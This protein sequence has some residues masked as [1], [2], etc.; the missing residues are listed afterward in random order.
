M[1]LEYQLEKKNRI[2]EQ[3]TEKQNI[4][5]GIPDKEITKK[6]DDA[7]K[8][9]EN[10][11]SQYNI[12]ISKSQYENNPI[13]LTN[14]YNSLAQICNDLTKNEEIIRQLN[15]ELDSKSK[16]NLSKLPAE[17]QLEIDKL[18]ND[19]S[20][21]DEQI[22]KE[23]EL[24]RQKQNTNKKYKGLEENINMNE[25]QRVVIDD[26]FGIYIDYPKNAVI[27][28]TIK[29]IFGAGLSTIPE[30]YSMSETEVIQS[31]SNIKMP[32][33]PTL[34]SVFIDTL[35]KTIGQG[36]VKQFFFFKNTID[37]IAGF[38]IGEV[39]GTMIPGL[40]NI[41]KDIKLLF[42]DPSQW[43][44][45][46][47]L[48]PIFDI[49]IPIPTFKF[50]LGALIPFL[51]F[52][53]RIPKIDPYNYFNKLTPFNINADPT[54][55]P[56]NWYEIM[57]NDIGK[58][59][60]ELEIN[61]KNI[62]LEKIKVLQGKIQKI[63]DDLNGV[64]KYESFIK[65]SERKIKILTLNNNKIKD[66]LNSNKFSQNYDYFIKKEKELKEN[67]ELINEENKKLSELRVS[68]DNEQK[69]LN[70]LNR[71]ELETQLS[72]YQNDLKELTDDE[73]PIITYK[74]FAKKALL[75]AYEQN[76]PQDTLVEKLSVLWDIG[77]NI[78]DNQVTE[79]LQKIGYDFTKN[80]YIYELKSLRDKF[81]LKFN[82]ATH[83]FKL[84]QLGFNLNDP[85]HLEKLKFL[86]R[87]NIDIKNADLMLIL[88]ELGMNL[89]NVLFYDIVNTLNNELSINISDLEILKKLNTIGFNFNNINTI[90]RLKILS[91][92]V[93][94]KTVAGYNN[95]I[96]KNVNLNNPYIETV[97]K[98]YFTLNLN[99]NS[100]DFLA[101]EAEILSTVTVQQIDRVKKILNFF[102]S[103]NTDLNL[104]FGKTTLSNNEFI[105]Y[106][107]SFDI[108]ET[109]SIMNAGDTAGLIIPN[110][111]EYK[112][113]II[114]SKTQWYEEIPV[115]KQIPGSYTTLINYGTYD[116]PIIEE[117]KP[118]KIKLYHDNG[119]V[120]K[121]TTNY[122][123]NVDESGV[124]NTSITY[125]Y[126]KLYCIPLSSR[127]ILD[128]VNR[129]SK[130]NIKLKAVPKNSLNVSN[131]STDISKPSLIQGDEY[132][133]VVLPFKGNEKFTGSNKNVENEILIKGVKEIYVMLDLLRNFVLNK[134]WVIDGVRIADN[135]SISVNDY[136]RMISTNPSLV[137]TTGAT[138]KINEITYDQL[139]GIYG[140]FDKLGLNIRDKEFDY[141]FQKMMDI[142]KI[143]IDEINILETKRKITLT[144]YDRNDSTGLYDIQK[145]ID[146]STTKPN[147][148]VFDDAR[149]NARIEIT[150]IVDTTKQ[151]QP[152]K[153]I[154]QFDSLNKMGFNFQNPTYDI[155]L[156]K[157]NG[158]L[159]NVS[160]FKTVDI[161]DALCALGWHYNSVESLNK[162]SGLAQLGFN[163]DIPSAAITDG[164]DM[165]DKLIALNNIG[166]NFN[167]PQWLNMINEL[168][169]I[170]LN[171]KDKDFEKAIEELISFGISFKDDDWNIKLQKL[172]DLGINFSTI[173]NVTN[174]YVQSGTKKWISQMS[175][176]ISLGI[177]F[178][179]DDWLIKY[180][181]A[182][183]LKKLGIDYLEIENRQKIAILN[184]LGVDFEQPEDDYM[185]KI[186]S[187]VQLKLISIPQNVVNTKIEYLKNREEKLTKILKRIEYLE[188]VLNGSIIIDIDNQ[189][190]KLKNLQSSY[191]I[192][193]KNLKS[194][195]ISNFNAIQINNLSKNLDEKC[196]LI[197]KLNDKIN[198][199]LDERKKT[200]TLNKI[201]IEAELF[202]LNDE[203]SKLDNKV[204][205]LNSDL[206]LVEL[207]KFEALEKIGVNFYDPNWMQ[208]ISMLLQYPFNFGMTDWKSLLPNVMYLIPRNPIL[209]WTKTIINT[210]T[211]V[212]T[213]PMK[214]IFELIK[215][216]IDLIGKVISIP[217]NP[218]KIPD[219]IIGNPSSTNENDWGIITRFRKLVELI[220]NLPTLDGM[221]DFLFTNPDG[222][223]LIDIFVKGFAEFMS[224]IKQ[225]TSN[226]SNQIKNL[227][228]ELGVLKQKLDTVTKDKNK[229]QNEL[230]S[231]LLLTDSIINGDFSDIEKL[232]IKLR[233]LQLV[234]TKN[235][236]V[237]E[238]SIRN[239]S[240]PDDILLILEKQLK[241]NCIIV[242]DL[243]KQIEENNK[244]LKELKNKPLSELQT[245]KIK[246]EN[247]LSN[248]DNV[249]NIGTI[250]SDI[251][252]KKLK[253]SEL[254][255]KVSV[256]GNFCNFKNNID[257]LIE[258][259]N[260]FLNNMNKTNPY[261]K[262]IAEKQKQ[263][264]KLKNKL[265]MLQ[266][267]INNNKNGQS[268]YNLI[269]N[270]NNQIQNNN[271]Q[272]NS[273]ESDLCKN[274][275]SM[276]DY[277][278]FNKM[279][280]IEELKR[281][282]ADIQNQIDNIKIN[283]GT[284]EQMLQTKL[285]IEAELEKLNKELKVLRN[286]QQEFNQ[287]NKDKESKFKNVITW[288]PTIINI[289]C[290]VP[291]FIVNICV[292]LFNAAGY[293]KNLPTLWEFSYVK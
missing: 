135:F 42:T 107:Y 128:I 103:P 87:L 58:D 204:Y 100:D 106:I 25:Y 274:K 44:F 201:D 277:E 133:P 73:K 250:Q 23:R 89:N 47:T 126:D 252:N 237:I 191:L 146:L 143:K 169:S 228:Q 269:N 285:E 82:N 210:I 271:L 3:I 34:L 164:V 241:E 79:F 157:L 96:K 275:N 105:K 208:N 84:Y 26:N 80:K 131:I 101:T 243:E 216:L 173:V 168:V 230:H 278:F 140:N 43:M 27:S 38:E 221:I 218:A 153:T 118:F 45:K 32:G 245:D 288:L 286:K 72:E 14:T 16:S 177:D 183:N 217:L 134:G 141:K 293:M 213:M 270:L 287:Q 142:L 33:L 110:N 248:I 284:N 193:I 190:K 255:E 6:I 223:M 54:K 247:Q 163:F 144:Y 93:D 200:I 60:E 283:S 1:S 199:L 48:G 224:L 154:I 114:E 264:N 85:N 170:G 95:A 86:S 71:L 91:K 9:R 92:Y 17:Y 119:Y 97:L 195:D 108:E 69:R 24:E 209:E 10:L 13:V 258:I 292:G 214:F 263:I 124:T 111:F 161:V 246:L 162:L 253:I 132:V 35:L 137:I 63:L 129:W 244:K 181:K 239:N 70:S 178:R 148:K 262:Q 165:D 231:Q 192:E 234:H 187:L 75:L 15:Q 176:L 261:D 37:L 123:Q 238:D 56:S 121:V 136:E 220:K 31:I 272:L 236:E 188:N 152:T 112:E 4:L 7:K 65:A 40:I 39:I 182:I 145:T 179:D 196:L 30:N 155:F 90:E 139:S 62:Q 77:V 186:E 22:A 53:I 290:C 227:N 28:E 158:L 254:S 76:I 267:N 19:L 159:F 74:Q 273:L 280:K 130:Y 55:I 67:C 291:K 115:K 36:F 194:I 78:F 160:A 49:N 171:M 265:N 122:S 225:L 276:S 281:N 172:K 64:N 215:K 212:I 149:Y 52:S 242:N 138:P 233:N 207:E 59:E 203:K 219:W 18:Y 21:I 257:K 156:N 117:G 279:S 259:M 174:S 235:I 206:I 211:T 50:D 198:K 94:I 197:T 147:P 5:A 185:Q 109:L 289:L 266:E 226:F 251:N 180:N 125:T 151:I 150:N 46:K 113:E 184:K 256:F 51:P 232:N 61:F 8:Q 66:N 2:I 202:S 282:N 29:C 102:D 11:L 268:N 41:L 205:K 120:Y 88:Q 229:K 20:K 260:N 167:K 175:N 249:Y 81:G 240:I 57:E 83:L 116:V 104:F 99:W 12:L 222:L 166:F 98:K 68:Y 127:Q 189:I